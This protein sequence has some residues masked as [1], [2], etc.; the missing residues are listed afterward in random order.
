MCVFPQMSEKAAGGHIPRHATATIRRRWSD[1]FALSYSTQRAAHQEIERGVHAVVAPAAPADE[2]T[3][4]EL[5]AE[6][7]ALLRRV[8]R[9]AHRARFALHEFRS[10]DLHLEEDF[11]HWLGRYGADLA[12][13]RAQAVAFI[14]MEYLEA[15]LLDRF[16]VS[17]VDVEFRVPITVFHRGELSDCANVL[18]AGARMAL[19]GRSL[20]DT[21]DRLADESLR[22]LEACAQV[23]LQL[24]RLY[25]QARWRI[26]NE[27][28]LM[29]I[30]A[31][32]ISLTL[33]YWELS[34]GSVATLST[35]RRWI[36]S[37][38]EN[39]SG[40]LRPDVDQSFAA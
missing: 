24:S 38:L 32:G 17:N 14:D 18:E 29:E 35:W 15:G 34:R 4:Q 27:S 21:A 36:D 2:A 39:R 6:I 22:R 16:H 7:H 23:F 20:M 11:R 28:F 3:P 30:P 33:N 40:G 31:R 9:M 5:A 10:Y 26:Q 12:A 19:E 8:P 25:A 1:L 37:L 13:G